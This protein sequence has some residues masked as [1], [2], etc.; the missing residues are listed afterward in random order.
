MITYT[1]SIKE[2]GEFVEMDV[3]A[4]PGPAT[5]KEIAAANLLSKALRHFQEETSGV[6]LKPWQR[7]DRAKG[8]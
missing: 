4:P 6:L 2:V 1:I 5:A 8:N 3:L 7:P